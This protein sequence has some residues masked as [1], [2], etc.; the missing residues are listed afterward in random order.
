MPKSSGGEAKVKPNAQNHHCLKN[1]QQGR[2]IH[3]KKLEIKTATKI[4]Q[5]QTSHIHI[6][7]RRTKETLN[8]ATLEIVKLLNRNRGLRPKLEKDTQ[9]AHTNHS[10]PSQGQVGDLPVPWS[11]RA[12]TLWRGSDL[13]LLSPNITEI[14]LFFFLSFS[15][16]KNSIYKVSSLFIDK[17]DLVLSFISRFMFCFLIYD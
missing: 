6:N 11:H 17:P 15:F 5:K 3:K 12:T 13:P 14:T 10:A 9:S 8:L 4:E 2:K 16:K 7:L 1:H